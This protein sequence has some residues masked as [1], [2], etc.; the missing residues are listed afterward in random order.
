MMTVYMHVPCVSDSTNAG[1]CEWPGNEGVA[2]AIIC[3][4]VVWLGW[5]GCCPM[6]V[7]PLLQIDVAGCS[8]SIV[9]DFCGDND[10]NS[11]F[12]GSTLISKFIL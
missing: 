4:A 3:V 5:F 6:S 12:L 10:C 2:S 8:R 1:I 9:C 7:V 11:L